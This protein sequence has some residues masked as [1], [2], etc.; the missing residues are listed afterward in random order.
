[1]HMH[2]GGLEES[3]FSFVREIVAYTTDTVC[4]SIC[5]ESEAEAK[6]K[7]K[8]EAEVEVAVEVEFEVP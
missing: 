6:A 2:M 3:G 1:M 8:A 4:S 7:A 5:T